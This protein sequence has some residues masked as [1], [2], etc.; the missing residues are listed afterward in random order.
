MDLFKTPFINPCME[1]SL[2]QHCLS[3]ASQDNVPS[4]HIPFPYRA[5]E[6]VALELP[7]PTR[8]GS[9][10]STTEE[11]KKP[12]DPRNSRLWVLSERPVINYPK[13]EVK[14]WSTKLI[15]M[16]IRKKDAHQSSVPFWNC[17]FQ[18]HNVK[19]SVC[20]LEYLHCLPKS[21][22][23]FNKHFSF[24]IWIWNYSSFQDFLS[25]LTTEDPLPSTT[26]KGLSWFW[27]F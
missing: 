16:V 15:D 27:V 6:K 11:R 26:G 14:V 1:Y 13:K 9:A 17:S 5:L 21:I 25:P 4:L 2:L 23:Q 7:Q 24:G 8:V 10:P 19:Y 22:N 3:W 12:A 20:A 18:N